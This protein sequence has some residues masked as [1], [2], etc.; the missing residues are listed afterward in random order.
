M[1]EI[2]DRMKE[3]F[4]KLT[5]FLSNNDNTQNKEDGDAA[6]R[7]FK[8]EMAGCIELVAGRSIENLTEDDI[9]ANGRKKGNALS[10]F[11][12]KKLKSLFPDEEEEDENEGEF[13]LPDNSPLA[14]FY[15]SMRSMPNDNHPNLIEQELGEDPDIK[16]SIKDYEGLS[17]SA[18]VGSAYSIKS[19]AKGNCE[20]QSEAG[21]SV[22]ISDGVI[23]ASKGGAYIHLKPGGDISIV[24]GKNGVI[25]LGGEEAKLTSLCSYDARQG[26]QTNFDAGLNETTVEGIPLL[27][28]AGGVLGTDSAQNL[29]SPKTT[30]GTFATKI[31][32]K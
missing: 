13:T 8:P 27:S 31:L 18:I 3:S 14:R 15:V 10:F 1:S 32:L 24:P 25:K 16:K 26:I 5:S 19:F 11:E 9:V 12:F 29:P 7:Y 4:S 6:F 20:L 22:F 2:H 30:L 28:S 21:G 17:E 23:I